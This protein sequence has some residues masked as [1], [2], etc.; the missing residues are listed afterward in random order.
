MRSRKVKAVLMALAVTVTALVSE[1]GSGVLVNAEEVPE[2]L[3]AAEV[4][5]LEGAPAEEE[6]AEK[7]IIV[8][9][10]NDVHNAYTQSIKDDTVTCLGYAAVAQY[11]KDME[12]TG[13]YVELLDAGDAIQGGVIGALSKGEYLVD[14]MNQTGYSIAVPGNHEFD[15][16]MTQF[17]NLAKN[18]AKYQYVSCNFIDLKTGEPVFDSYEMKQYGDI[19]V[20]YIGITTPETY[21]KSTPTYFQDENG[22]YIYGFCEGD[23][24]QELYEQVQIAINDAEAAGADYIVAIGHAG[25]DPSSEPWTSR[26]IIA[27]TTGLDAFIDG[28]SHSTIPSEE[29]KDKNG[30]TVVLSSTGTKLASLGKMV[31]KT[32]GTITTELVTDYTNQDPGTLE[33][34][35]G[36][37]EQFDALQNKVVANTAVDLVIND[38]VSG[39]R[40]VRNQETNLGDLCADAYRTMLGADIAFV[41]GGGVRVDVKKGDVTY[42]NIISVHPFGNMA[43]LIEATG[44]QI[45]D[46]L[47][48]GSS[49]AGIGEGAGESGGFLQ[50]S[51]LTY[52]I[53]TTIPSS[54]VKDDKQAFVKVDG[55]YRVKNVKVGGEALDLNK[56]YKLASHNYMLKSGGDGYTMFMGDKILK[57]EVMVDNEVLINYI[58]DSLGGVVKMDSVYANPYGEGRI[59]VITAYQAATETEDGYVEYVQG[60]GTAREVLKATGSEKPDPEPT[61]T[62][63]PEPTPTPDPKPTPTP[64]PKPEE[65]SSSTGNSN[66]NITGDVVTNKNQSQQEET[67]SAG[68]KTY[69]KLTNKNK[70]GYE[71]IG[72]AALIPA[73]A[74][75][76]AE[77]CAKESTS[78]Q[79]AAAAVKTALKNCKQFAVY[80]ISLSGSNGAEIHDVGGYVS[81]TMPVPEGFSSGKGLTVYRLES[82]GTLTKCETS[83]TDGK[84]TFKTN[85]FSTYILA[86]TGV[87]SAQTSDD[88][89]AQAAQ[90][91]LLLIA[92][93]MI[94]CVEYRRRNRGFVN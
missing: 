66:I 67:Y 28:H 45:L 83:V 36:I 10:T 37:T 73:G 54:V 55:E 62:P 32:D 33:Y 64:D 68:D 27:N 53:D 12:A 93:V 5:T 85:H 88:G 58:V 43:C 44:Q 86:Q 61:P 24:G 46:A 14:I 30:D 80:D 25:V 51:G 13:D 81:V 49:A 20:A 72:D 94:L 4:E 34:V 70:A 91:A 16:G 40:M 56:T 89:M 75:F 26:E 71:I 39:K 1:L 8:L 69:R 60:D 78:Y 7:D 77:V 42:G 29:C 9:F 31:I 92:G 48:L 11:K 35:N 63:D 38:P 23:D 76:K 41:N 90:A 19:D 79:A 50:V 59:R 17:L 47:E 87:V 74:Q 21:T 3:A 6:T 57:D 22:N 18:K 65:P 84:I 15:F 82:N 52:E 2:E